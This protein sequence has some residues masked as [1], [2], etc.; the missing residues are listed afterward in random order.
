MNSC[1]LT[2]NYDYVVMSIGVLNTFIVIFIC[3]QPY[4]FM[5]VVQVDRPESQF[6]HIVSL[7]NYTQ[8]SLQWFLLAHID[9]TVTWKL[10]LSRGSTGSALITGHV[11]IGILATEIQTHTRVFPS[12]QIKFSVYSTERKTQSLPLGVVLYLGICLHKCSLRFYF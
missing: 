8:S 5:G 3:L 2:N 12:L 6:S 4:L 9:V 7:K 1:I 10:A 11:G